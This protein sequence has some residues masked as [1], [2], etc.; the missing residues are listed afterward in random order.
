MNVKRNPTLV[1]FGDQDYLYLGEN[2]CPVTI[3]ESFDLHTA[4]GVTPF[5]SDGETHV[6]MINGEP[7][8]VPDADVQKVIDY[9]TDYEAQATAEREK[10][11]KA[12]AERQKKRLAKIAKLRKAE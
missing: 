2:F 3:G 11:F 12:K 5:F 6:R 7:S 9:S 1:K 10:E 4:P 8:A